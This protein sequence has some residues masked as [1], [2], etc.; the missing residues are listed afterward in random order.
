MEY[1]TIK[2]YKLSEEELREIWRTEYCQE[3]IITFDHILVRC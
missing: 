3:D 2:P 1:R